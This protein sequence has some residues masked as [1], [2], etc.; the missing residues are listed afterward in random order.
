MWSRSDDSTF[1]NFEYLIT[2]LKQGSKNFDLK[3]SH[4]ILTELSFL[5]K[6]LTLK[7]PTRITLLFLKFGIDVK[8]VLKSL[9]NS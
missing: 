8:I 3:N 6:R 9:Q 7:S 1:S 4:N 5:R 2:L